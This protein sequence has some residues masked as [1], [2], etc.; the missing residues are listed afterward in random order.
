[1]SW[2]TI[3]RMKTRRDH[4]GEKHGK[5]T[6]LSFDK[7]LGTRKDGRKTYDPTWLCMC[8]CGRK[9]IVRYR[10]L[11]SGQTK[12]C[13]QCPKPTGNQHSEWEGYGEISADLWNSYKHAAKARGLSFNLTI[14]AAWKLF[15]KQGRKCAL[16]GWELTFPPS[17]KKKKQKTASL[18]RI[19]PTKGYSISNVQW[20]HRDINRLKSNMKNGDFIDMCKAV[21]ARAASRG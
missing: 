2:L 20:V 13:A 21:A 5:L 7:Y 16:T 3:S 18:D 12:T 10:C 14:K 4:T 1:M 15:E 6:I 9:K 8:E 17:Y 19:S 11:R